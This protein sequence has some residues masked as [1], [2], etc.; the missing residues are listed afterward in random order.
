MCAL[1]QLLFFNTSYFVRNIFNR[2]VSC[3][4]FPAI[5]NKN[6]L[7]RVL[8]NLGGGGAERPSN[9]QCNSNF[10]LYVFIYVFISL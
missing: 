3:S 9:S 6:L 1:F 2:V 4:C 10:E 7:T 5:F 8:V